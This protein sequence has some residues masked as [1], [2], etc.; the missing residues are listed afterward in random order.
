MPLTLLD[1]SEAKRAPLSTPAAVLAPAK[2]TLTPNN[3]QGILSGAGST[4]GGFSAAK[5]GRLTADWSRIPRAADQILRIDL[6]FLRARARE[7]QINSPIGSKFLQMLRTNLVGPHGIRIAFKLEKQRKRGSEILD[8]KTN[9]ALNKAW[10][11][12][13]RREYCTVHGKY[14]WND[15]CR[16]A[17]DG[18]GR[19]GEIIVRKVYLPKTQNPFGFSLQLIQ[20]DQLDD[21]YNILG[22]PKQNQIR[23]GVEVDRFQKPLAYHIFEGNPYESGFG[24]SNRIPVPANQ[25][26]HF[27]I[28]RFI[29]QT[30]GYPLLAPV[31]YDMKML[32][33]Y[34]EAE[35][36][37]ARSGAQIF[38]AIEQAGSESY[39]GD[40]EDAEEG[41][42][43]LDVENG[44]L[45]QLPPGSTLK[46][47]SPEHPT[48]AFNPFVER[49]LRL[50]ASGMGVA[51]HE[52]GNDLAGVNY[53]SGRLGVLEERDY[54]MELQNL[55]IDALNRPVYEDW[56]KSALLNG[57]IDLPFDPER[58]MDDEAIEFIPRRWPWVDPLKDS[59]AST[60]DVQN[61]FSTHAEI[62]HQHGKDWR[63]VYKQL[64]AEQEFAD[65]LGIQVG[66]DIRADALSEVN[67]GAPDESGE[68]GTDSKPAK[69]EPANPPAKK[70]PKK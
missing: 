64:K 34:F 58:Y 50:I 66:T 47:T 69:E 70:K 24:A 2:R 30:R 63:A 28:P 55:M 22:S 8:D 27:F 48:T 53:S 15:V 41:A 14:T 61:G 3:M 59:Q 10:R 4:F 51:Y 5:P 56:I 60:L 42:T 62:L 44:M 23:L 31:M 7:Q 57:A 54:F 49:S 38:G 25:I 32:D 39:A 12:W 45:I 13:Q 68:P 52:L 20:A 6:R 18:I 67:D 36:V 65:E 16:M 1:L 9:D 46:N 43:R 26:Y 11:K 21:N 17:A 40:G 29:G 19:D 37:A 35:L 33:G